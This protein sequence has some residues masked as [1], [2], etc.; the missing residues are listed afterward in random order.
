MSHIKWFREI[1]IE[2]VPSVG[3]K[4][5]SLGEM[6]QALTSKGVTIPN[7][8]AITA[9][10]YFYFIDEVSGSTQ[11]AFGTEC[12]SCISET[13]KKDS[14]SRDRKTRKAYETGQQRGSTLMN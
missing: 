5:A 2:D 8:Y 14:G 7:G 13:R 12:R 11:T 10:A 9:Q 6:Y 4:N 1:S 3:G